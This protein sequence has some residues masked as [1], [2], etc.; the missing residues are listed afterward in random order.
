MVTNPSKQKNKTKGNKIRRV[1]LAV[2]IVSSR[3]YLESIKVGVWSLWVC[4]DNFLFRIN[5]SFYALFT[6]SAL[7]L[8]DV[9]RANVHFVCCLMI[10]EEILWI[11]FFC[12]FI[13]I[14]ECY[15]TTKHLQL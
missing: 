10:V 2:M 8:I 12:L 13:C 1:T 11:L 3:L 5:S 9:I 4:E 15:D 6:I 7:W 14:H